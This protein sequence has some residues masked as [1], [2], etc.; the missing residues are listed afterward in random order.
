MS[1]LDRMARVRSCQPGKP[2]QI[3]RCLRVVVGIGSPNGDHWPPKVICV[4]GLV[5]RDYPIGEAQIKKGKQPS[6]R[7]CRQA[8]RHRCCLRDFVPIILNG[9]IPKA[10]GQGFVRRS[11]RAI[12]NSQ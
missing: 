11:G 10:A 2:I 5:E 8:M 7:R 12:G 1:T 6:V 3:R 4:F 9:S